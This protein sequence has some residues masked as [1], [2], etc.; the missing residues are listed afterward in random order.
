MIVI[1][2]HIVET[3]FDHYLPF[4]LTNIM[5]IVKMEHR[6]DLLEGTSFKY[7]FDKTSCKNIELLVY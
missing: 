6:Y 2:H 5:S 7:Y 3:F 4:S 1:N